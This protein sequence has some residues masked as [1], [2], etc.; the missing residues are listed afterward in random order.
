MNEL[1]EWG[2]IL[3]IIKLLIQGGVVL[4]VMLDV[5]N[6]IEVDNAEQYLENMKNGS[7]KYVY[8]WYQFI[9]TLLGII[10]IIVKVYFLG[11]CV[12]YIYSSVV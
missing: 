6:V 9:G 10:D 5:K 4:S 11:L 1:F 7:E 3:I 8:A 12:L 2:L